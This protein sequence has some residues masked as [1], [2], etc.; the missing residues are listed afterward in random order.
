MHFDGGAVQAHLF[1]PDG[2]DLLLLQPGEDP[3]QHPGLAPAVHPRVDRMP[4][5]KLFGQPPPFATL[6][7]HIQQS[8]EQLQIGHAHVAALPRQTISDPLNIDSR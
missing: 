8:V 5:A 6:L 3:V 1:N 7:H 4:V 2:Q